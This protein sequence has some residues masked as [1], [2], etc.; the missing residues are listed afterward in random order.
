MSA[1]LLLLAPL[2]YWGLGVPFL[3]GRRDDSTSS[4][5]P[6]LGGAVAGLFCE[7][8]FATGFS[9]RTTM[10]AV[11]TLAA[12]WLMIFGR[13]R[14]VWLSLR[15]TY[16]LYLVALVPALASP[17]PILGTWDGDWL[18]LFKAGRTL[19]ESGT[20]S[21]ESLQRPPLFGAGAGPLWVFADGL[22]S[23][24]IFA[25]VMSAGALGACLFVADKLAPGISRIRLLAPLVLAPFF[26]HHTA[27]CWG[28][29]MAAGLLLAAGT[30]LWRATNR[31][32]VWWAGVWFALAVAVHQSSLFYAPLLLAIRVTACGFKFADLLAMTGVFAVTGLALAGGFELWTV[33]HYGLAAKIAANPSVAQRDPNVSLAM[34]TF[35]VIV[36]SFLGWAPV[37]NLVRWAGQPDARSAARMGKESFWLVTSWLQVL[38]GTFLGAYAAVLLAGGK[39]F[40]AR[41]RNGFCSRSAVW[42]WLAV[43]LVILCN[44]LLNPS[45]SS[46]G[47]MQTGLVGLGLAGFLAL[48][49]GL[50]KEVPRRWT[51]AVGLT[52]VFGTLPWLV[53]NVGVSAGLRFS[54]TFRDKFVSGSEGDWERL[55]TNHLVPL[56]LS[57]FPLWQ[58]GLLVALLVTAWIARQNFRRHTTP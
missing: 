9:A 15:N 38:A 22:A 50:A 54:A 28:K 37:E 34:N 13:E 43:G 58:I 3:L 14:R 26:L 40:F 31:S 7:L 1:F 20:L 47:S 52:T 17:F 57:G 36:T 6:L 46:N 11:M 32:G 29:L 23:F 44:G 48:S 25:A 2:I 4:L 39:T 49:I 21:G 5:A 51:W 12:V 24:Q 42:L 45:S 53:L 18:F 56:G 8:A 19:W 27:A 55:R 16:A 10:I 33:Q 35:L 41:C 30:E